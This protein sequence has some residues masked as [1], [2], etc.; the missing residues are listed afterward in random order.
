M[1]YFALLH[2]PIYCNEIDYFLLCLDL[3]I[4]WVIGIVDLFYVSFHLRMT[5]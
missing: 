4:Q 3:Q 2:M 5:Q 1:Y